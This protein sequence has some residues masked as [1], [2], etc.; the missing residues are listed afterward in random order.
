[1]HI[2]NQILFHFQSVLLVPC[3][4][5][6]AA[7]YNLVRYSRN[8]NCCCRTLVDYF[9]SPFFCWLSYQYYQWLPT[10]S[11]FI[12]IQRRIILDMGRFLMWFDSAETLG[13]TLFSVYFLFYYIP[14]YNK[15]NPATEAVT[16]QTQLINELH[17]KREVIPEA[18]WRYWLHSICN[19]LCFIVVIAICGVYTMPH[20]VQMSNEEYVKVKLWCWINPKSAH[21]QIH[22]WFIEEDASMLISF[23]A[24]TS[25]L[26]LLCYFTREEQNRFSKGCFK[27]IWW[28]FVHCKKWVVILTIRYGYLSCNI[29][30]FCNYKLSRGIGYPQGMKSVYLKRYRISTRNDVCISQD[31]PCNI[32]LSHRGS[33]VY[34]P[35]VLY[36]CSKV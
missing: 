19:V 3:L 15:K 6:L 18:S 5:F 33:H 24:L 28:I 22:F 30:I 31:T 32:T 11:Y 25:S 12:T 8:C 2:S 13:L 36:F 1:M 23:I 4:L 29:A 20:V 7:L 9:T 17:A 10:A 34:S 21:V 16:E 26:I 27:N 14:F 35:T